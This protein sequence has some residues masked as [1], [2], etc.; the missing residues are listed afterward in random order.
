MDPLGL[1]VGVAQLLRHAGILSPRIAPAPV[2]SV[3]RPP[4]TFPAALVFPLVASSLAAPVAAASRT[5]EATGTR[6]RYHRFS[7]APA[8]APWLSHL[9][10]QDA[11]RGGPG[12]VVPP[13]TVVPTGRVEII[14][15]YGDP[16]IHLDD[17]GAVTLPPVCLLGPRTRPVL[18]AATGT[19]GLVIAA[20]HPWA[21]GALLGDDVAELTDRFVDLADRFGRVAAASLHDRVAAARSPEVRAG[22]VQTFLA[23]LLR[24]RAIDDVAAA[25]ARIIHRRGGRVAASDLATEL[26]VGE[27]HL[28]RR[29]RSA[30]G[31]GPKRLAR[32]ARAQVALAG[33]QG[34]RAWP[35]IALLSGYAD[36]SHLIREIKAFTGRTPGQ[37]PGPRE[38]T[39]LM[40]TYNATG[41]PD[42]PTTFYL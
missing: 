2:Q 33:L 20:L 6:A 18:A 34:G 30:V 26:G 19:T 1:E 32:L 10:V 31:V 23:G 24:H 8:L 22:I 27:R 11:P 28:R 9:W 4:N 7:P 41:E 25:C 13:T 12:T 38:A 5:T 40:R 42:A 37:L 16:F 15:R 39:L 36:Q 14:V 29:V 35:E 17:E 3:G 21:A